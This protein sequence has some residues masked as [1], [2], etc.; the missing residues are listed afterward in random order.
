MGAKVALC[1]HRARPRNLD[2]STIKNLIF[3]CKLVRQFEP[4]QAGAGAVNAINGAEMS[5]APVQDKLVVVGI[6]TDD[7]TLSGSQSR[8]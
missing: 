3:Q 2:E 5:R 6:K 7:F 4:V 1:N 8:S